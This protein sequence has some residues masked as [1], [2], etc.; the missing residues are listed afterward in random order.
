M[1][2]TVLLTDTMMRHMVK[3][4]TER[5]PMAKPLMRNTPH[6]QRTAKKKPD[7]DRLPPPVAQET[8]VVPWLEVADFKIQ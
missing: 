8:F 5:Q 3:P 1:K 4:L 7:I 2:S 6:P